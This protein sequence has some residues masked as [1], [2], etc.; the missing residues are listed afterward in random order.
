MNSLTSNLLDLT[1]MQEGAIL[2][3]LEWCPADE[4]VEEARSALAARL[5]AHAI[6]VVMPPD[7]VVWCD[8]ALVG[9]L[10]V[11]LI[12][13]A[14]RHA[15]GSAISITVRLAAAS[16]QL[17]V[18]DDGPGVPVGQELEVFKK[19]SRGNSDTASNG[20]GTGLGLAICTAVA[21]LHGG[22]LAVD[23]G[24]GARFVLTMPQPPLSALGLAEV[25]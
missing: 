13:N 1:R 19:F 24:P 6:S 18:E 21:H 9:Q 16:W 14:T 11:N 12:D 25:E 15:P 22:T 3:S 2:P 23:A 7:A 17:V 5:E 8:P 20:G 10:L 4:L